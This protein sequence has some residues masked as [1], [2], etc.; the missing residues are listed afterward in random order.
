MVEKLPV[1]RYGIWEFHEQT[2]NCSAKAFPRLGAVSLLLVWDLQFRL[3]LIFKS[4]TEI[5]SNLPKHAIKS[6]YSGKI[7]AAVIPKTNKMSAKDMLGELFTNQME[8]LQTTYSLCVLVGKMPQ[9][10]YLK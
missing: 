10:F 5:R 7:D 3:S 4:V 1:H 6:K 9:S 2:R 8:T